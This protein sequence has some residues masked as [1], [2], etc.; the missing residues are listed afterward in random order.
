MKTI[1]Q[2]KRVLRVIE[3]D[4]KLIFNHSCPLKE[5]ERTKTEPEQ[6]RTIKL[7]N[8]KLN[9]LFNCH[10]PENNQNLLWLGT[11]ILYYDFSIKINF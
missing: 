10:E 11:K 4:L 8:Y 3:Q 1:K 5:Y 9:K 6:L 7:V 2:L